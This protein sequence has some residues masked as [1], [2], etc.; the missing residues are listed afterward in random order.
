M[1]Y[2]IILSN[3]SFLL[4]ADCA[5]DAVEILRAERR[6]GPDEGWGFEMG[7]VFSFRDGELEVDQ[8]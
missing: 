8:D 6:M 3:R 7:T 1:L 5:E 2:R 4:E